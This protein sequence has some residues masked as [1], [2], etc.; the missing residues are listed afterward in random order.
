MLYVHHIH[1]VF[2]EN[3][4]GIEPP[5][6]GVTDGGEPPCWCWELNLGPLSS[7]RGFDWQEACSLCTMHLSFSNTHTQLCIGI[8]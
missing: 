3:E 4:R 7:P 2:K 8:R 5:G 6:T 1:V